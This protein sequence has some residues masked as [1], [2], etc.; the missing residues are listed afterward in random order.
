[1]SNRTQKTGWIPPGWREVGHGSGSGAGKLPKGVEKV[2]T[3]VLAPSCRSCH[4]NREIS[5]DFGTYANFHQDSDLN[6]LALM[7][8]C[9]NN[10]TPTATTTF[11]P[12]GDLSDPGG[13]YMPLAHLTFEK[14][15]QTQGGP[16][17]LPTND[18]LTLDHEVDRLARDFGFSA[19]VA[20]YCATNP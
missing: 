18:S 15:W 9:K 4:F 13:R 2:Y 3:N 6:Q 8:Q 5:L 11:P 17:T 19:G 16:I 7:P 10:G 12:T 14:F 1:M 20:G